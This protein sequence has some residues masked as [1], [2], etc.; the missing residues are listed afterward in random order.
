MTI[1]SRRY[2]LPL[3]VLLLL[4]LIPVA[5]HSYAGLRRDECREPEA[6]IGY[7][8]ATPP[9]P[10]RDRRMRKRFAAQEW[11]EGT[12]DPTPQAP[13]LRYVVIRSLDAKRLY[14]RPDDRLLS[15]GSPER[16]EIEW[17]DTEGVPLPIHHSRYAIPSRAGPRRMVGYLL[18]YQGRPVANGALVQLRSAPAQLLRGRSPMTLFLVWGEVSAAQAEAAE[19]HAR[20]WLLAAWES[21]RE[22]CG[23]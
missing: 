1:P 19:D 12:L 9:D 21:Y 13:A 14:Y 20:R 15:G 16:R 6:L 4:T 7:A 8:G 2:Q 17:L 3:T 18:T 11:W 5:V 23:G 10:G 22:A